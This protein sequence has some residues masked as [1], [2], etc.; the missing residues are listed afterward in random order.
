MVT[1]KLKPVGMIGLITSTEWGFFVGGRWSSLLLVGLVGLVGAV[2][3][4]IV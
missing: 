1:R 4:V 3:V 2:V